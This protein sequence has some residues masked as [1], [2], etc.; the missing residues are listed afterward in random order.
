LAASRQH[1]KRSEPHAGD[2]SCAMGMIRRV[3]GAPK[4]PFIRPKTQTR[5][6]ASA[7]RTSLDNPD[8]Q[9]SRGLLA[10]ITGRPDVLNFRC[11]Q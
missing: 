5:L 6:N 4:I 9:R 10:L 2:S 11:L 8:D 3:A 1:K 7:P